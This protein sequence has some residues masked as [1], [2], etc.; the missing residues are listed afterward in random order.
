MVDV[1]QLNLRVWSKLQLTNENSQIKLVGGNV[2][3]SLDI[4]ATEEFC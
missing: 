4:H 3:L 2:T 1:R